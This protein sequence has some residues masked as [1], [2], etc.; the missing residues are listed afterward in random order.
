MT[1]FYTIPIFNQSVPGIWDDFLRIRID[2]M[3]HNYNLELSPSEI[4]RFMQEYAA[5]W[6]RYGGSYAYG[7]YDAS[8]QMLGSINGMV[9]NGVGQ[10]EQLHVSP[11]H[12]GQHIGRV[13]LNNAENAVAMMKGRRLELISL[14]RAETFYQSNGY[15][16]RS[17]CGY[18]KKIKSPRCGTIPVFWCRPDLAASCKLSAETVHQV[19]KEHWPMFAYCDHECNILGHSIIDPQENVQISLSSGS[20]DKRFVQRDLARISDRYLLHQQ[21]KVR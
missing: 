3:R 9:Y 2:T 17:L 13:L 6:A 18:F 19:N 14:S 7:A 21:S 5:N 16:N 11:A 12:Q 4:Q 8:G 1:E 10:V 15:Q 20:F